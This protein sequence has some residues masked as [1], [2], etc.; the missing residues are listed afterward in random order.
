MDNGAQ[1]QLL[2]ES[3]G[4]PTLIDPATAALTA[5]QVARPR[6]GLLSFQPLWELVVAQEPDLLE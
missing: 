4:T 3:A 6:S 5:S 1:T 2:A